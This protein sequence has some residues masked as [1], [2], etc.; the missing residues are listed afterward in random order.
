MKYGSSTKY[1][2]GELR[3]RTTYVR[4]FPIG[5]ESEFVHRI[6]RSVREARKHTV[7]GLY[8]ENK[9]NPPLWP[10]AWSLYKSGL[11]I[12][13]VRSVISGNPQTRKKL[14]AVQTKTPAQVLHVSKNAD[15]NPSA[16][17]F[18]FRD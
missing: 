1:P 5:V 3:L 11:S 18:F 2:P 9:S 10:W 13:S 17:E 16:D 14:R 4:G 8:R 15:H 7:L 6:M 12:I